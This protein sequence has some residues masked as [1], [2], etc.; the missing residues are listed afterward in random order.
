MATR[1]FSRSEKETIPCQALSEGRWGNA[2]LFCCRF[3]GRR[4]VV[5]DFSSSPAV[6]AATWGRWM[7]RREYCALKRLQGIEGVA[8]LPFLMDG[9]ALVYLYQPG[10]T[11]RKIN[12]RDIPPDFFFRL[13]KLVC[14]M[15]ER[16]VVHL[17]IRNRRNILLRPDG[18]PG[19][20]DF[21]SCMDLRL[22]PDSFGR[23]LKEIDLS[24]VYKTWYKL[25][26]DL[27]DAR[28]IRILKNIEKRRYLW[29]FRGYPL[30]HIK[31]HRD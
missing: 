30:E 6:V 23:L 5:K 9:Y 26:P 8:G 16:S 14:Q 22:I 3:K 28:R 13:E 2:R 25:R 21:Q 31:K 10:Q 11:L 20:L 12:S 1:E 17:D 7:V 24:G 19:L 18:K 15:H 29:M 27:M 4:W